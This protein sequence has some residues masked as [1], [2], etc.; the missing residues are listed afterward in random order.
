[1]HYKPTDPQFRFCYIH[2]HIDG[3][4]KT[5][6]RILNFVAGRLRLFQQIR[7]NVPILRKTGYADSVVDAGQQ[8]AQQTNRKSTLQTSK[9]GVNQRILVIFTFFSYNQT[10]KSIILH[11]F[12]LLQNDSETGRFFANPT[13]FI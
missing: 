2:F 8:Y 11:D 3:T 13:D 12:K 6:C 10:V 4:S 9:K 1:M 7:G 5:P